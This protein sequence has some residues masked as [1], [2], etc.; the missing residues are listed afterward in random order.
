MATDIRPNFFNL[1]T[2]DVQ[3]MQQEHDFLVTKTE[4]ATASLGLDGVTTIDGLLVTE[5]SILAEP[6][7][8]PEVT[9]DPT[10]TDLKNYIDLPSDQDRTKSAR[11]YSVF[12]AKSNNLQRIDLRLQVAKITNTSFVTISLVSLL[13]PLTPT[14]ELGSTILARRIF[15]LNELPDLTNSNPVVLDFS[16]DNDR[17]GISLTV[18]N[19]YAILIEFTRET[20]SLDVLR[21]F[22]SNKQETSSIN[23]DLYS[24]IFFGSKFQQ[25]FFNTQASFETL[26]IYHKV[27]AAAV[28]IAP[29]VVYANGRAIRIFQPQRY[30]GLVDRG[31]QSPQNYI[32]VEWKEVT[33]ATESAARTGNTSVSRLEDS[34]EIKVL[35]Q[36]QYNE[37]I[38]STKTLYAVIAV[39]Q[40]R[41]IL[42]FRQEQSF[43]LSAQS[44]L[45]YHDWLVPQNLQPSLAALS[46]LEQRPADLL[47]IADNVP[48]EIPLTKFDGSLAVDA[49]G[50]KQ[51]DRISQVFLDL[52]LDGGLNKQSLQMFVIK[53]TSSQPSYRTFA[54]TLTDPNNKNLLPYTYP[55]D[56]KQLAVDTFYNIR[57]VTASGNE[58]YIQ[59]YDRAFNKANPVTGKSTSIRAKQY[60]IIAEK[61]DI[62]L[63]IDED[64]KLGESSFS[65]GVAGQELVGYRVSYR[66]NEPTIP[67]GVASSQAV[68]SI[69]DTLLSNNDYQ[70]APLPVV[71]R[72][73][74]LVENRDASVQAVYNSGD[75]VLL[76]NGVDIT[77]SGTSDRDKGGR[78]SPTTVFGKLLFASASNFL[79]KKV[80]LRNADG[81][82]NTQQSTTYKVAIDTAGKIAFTAIGLGRGPNSNAGF[83]QGEPMYIYIDDRPALDASSV[84]ITVVFNEFSAAAIDIY[85]LGSKRYFTGKEIVSAGEHLI[86]GQVQL[87]PN[88]VAIDPID[89]KVYFANGEDPIGT[90]SIQYLRLDQTIGK[91][92]YYLTSAAPFGTFAAAPIPNTET[93]LNAA[94]ANSDIVIKFGGVDIRSI[95]CTP[96]GSAKIVPDIPSHTLGQYE[97][98]INPD[99]GKIIFGPGFTQPSLIQ[100]QNP[101]LTPDTL[102]EASY[103]Q[104]QAQ[105][106][107]TV[108]QTFAVYS[109]RYDINLDGRIDETDVAIFNAAYGS[110]V[111]DINYLEA[112]DFNKDG[113][114]DDNDKSDLINHFGTVST[115]N[116]LYNDATTARITTLF[117]YDKNDPTRRINFVRAL[118][119]A[120]TTNELGKTVFFINNQ[121]PVDKRA[122][123][124]LVFGYPNLLEK[125][126]NSFTVS[127]EVPFV[128]PIQFGSISIIDKT[129]ETNIRTVVSSSTVS[130]TV[131]GAVVYDTSFLFTPPI[132]ETSSFLFASSWLGKHLDIF[133][134]RKMATP[135]EYEVNQRQIKGPFDIVL[136]GNQFASDGTF[137]ELVIGPRDAF[138]ADGL[139]DSD[140]K[141]LHGVPIE[142]SKFKVILRI[143]TN[144]GT[145][146]IDEWIWNNLKVDPI[147]KTIRLSVTDSLDLRH[148]NK[149]RNGAVVLQPFGVTPVQVSLKPIFAGGDVKNDLSNILVYREEDPQILPA[150][151]HTDTP[152]PSDNIIINNLCDFTGIQPR[153]TAVL[154]ELKSLIEQKVSIG[155]FGNDLV[156]VQGC[157]IGYG[158]TSLPIRIPTRIG[159]ICFEACAPMVSLNPSTS[160]NPNPNPY[161]PYP[162][163][164]PYSYYYPTDCPSCDCWIQI[165]VGKVDCGYF[166]VEYCV[167]PCQSG[168]ALLNFNWAACG[169]VCKCKE[170]PPKPP[171]IGEVSHLQSCSYHFAANLSCGEG[172]GSPAYYWD[173]GDGVN[174]STAREFDFTYAQPGTYKV[175]LTATCSDGRTFIDQVVIIV[176]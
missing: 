110:S 107:S 99:K 139:P 146:Q 154:C 61:G 118:S 67:S 39:V 79:G 28:Q 129:N 80:V 47:F 149:G 55:Y 59:D 19:Y 159:D 126:I 48:Y 32:V 111:G 150:H 15:R 116:S 53:E 77:F 49:E 148:R 14:S 8:Y 1:Q 135:L 138:F 173:L 113:K 140:G 147:S 57:A 175:T 34:F 161:Y 84:P 104:L 120:P 122:V 71:N 52:Y 81:R 78:G 44:N 23:S 95:N 51:T 155:D 163:S 7:L 18:G 13:N 137:I 164:Y 62:V 22:H 6:F 86:A 121:T 169:Y 64:L 82:D 93:A 166:E 114:I 85:N 29:G 108:T 136:G 50:Q 143:P 119:K 41:N 56:S 132:R 134:R 37:L 165:K 9:Q 27:Y 98:A 89:G 97:I 17:A 92:D 128:E 142:E 145:N 124:I 10:R 35:S 176:S 130:K 168:S 75:L 105:T 96:E 87:D 40:D 21:V 133:S 90:V 123:Y 115:G 101:I 3:D 42:S 174:S 152:I 25:G 16:G 54:L 60:E 102:V 72:D 144:D 127:T 74:L 5:D 43:T 141:L 106:I 100:G 112:A 33:A 167:D 109:S 65:S 2:L 117:A 151:N 125:V 11:V 36:P 38:Q 156:M 12:L 70:F 158:G 157:S 30:L 162:Y 172:E 83:A 103:Y 171:I 24:W 153:L 20:A 4:E 31:G 46:L 170:E 69:T 45:S 88:Q 66:E 91:I 73:G 131:S 63:Q 160:P 26:V 94:I 68:A 76:V 58:I